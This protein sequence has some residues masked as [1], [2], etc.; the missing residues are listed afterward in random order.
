MAMP[1]LRRTLWLA[2]Q[3]AVLKPANSFRDK[4]ERYIAQ[5]RHGLAPVSPDTQAV[6]F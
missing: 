2:S 6:A 5:V 3:T 4:F 1:R